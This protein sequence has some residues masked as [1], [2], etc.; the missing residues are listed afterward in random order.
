MS[1][2]LKWSVSQLTERLNLSLFLKEDH[3]I[4]ELKQKESGGLGAQP[5]S[6]RLALGGWLGR[7]V[8]GMARPGGGGRRPE[9]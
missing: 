2:N 7:R 8:G 3:F 4:L 6:P 5:A 1:V 9:N